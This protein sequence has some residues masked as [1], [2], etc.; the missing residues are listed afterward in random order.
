MHAKV[1]EDERIRR[2]EMRLSDL[3]R[4]V[5]EARA[6]LR[7]ARERCGTL[8]SEMENGEGEEEEKKEEEKEE[9]SVEVGE[10]IIGNGNGDRDGE[11]DGNASGE[12]GVEARDGS[13]TWN[14]PMKREEYKRYGRQLIMP[15]IGIRGMF[16]MSI[17]LD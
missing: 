6:E 14:W 7:N 12:A 11:Y 13:T 4:Q 8:I 10:D 16:S 9:C 1:D 3:D 5:L 2:L 15:E 17:T